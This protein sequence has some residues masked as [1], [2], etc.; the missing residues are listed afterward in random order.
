M[1]FVCRVE[2]FILYKT[3]WMNDYILNE[4]VDA[5]RSFNF[6]WRQ[7]HW[8]FIFENLWILQLF[9]YNITIILLAAILHYF[10]TKKITC[11]FS[12]QSVS[13]VKYYY[14]NSKLKNKEYGKSYH[15][16]VSNVFDLISSRCVQKKT[17]NSDVSIHTGHDNVVYP[18]ELK[19]MY[20]LNWKGYSWPKNGFWTRIQYTNPTVHGV[21]RD[22][23][24]PFKNNSMWWRRPSLEHC[25]EL[26]NQKTINVPTQTVFLQTYFAKDF[27]TS[28]SWIHTQSMT[29]VL[30]VIG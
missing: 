26:C 15:I 14:L 5:S 8:L 9:T 27:Q 17:L 2:N 29:K 1:L 16:I 23:V 3:V 25:I 30:N 28:S 13:I 11:E 20:L 19:C 22:V 7:R 10:F 4:F 12:I 6:K 18:I 24:L 21:D